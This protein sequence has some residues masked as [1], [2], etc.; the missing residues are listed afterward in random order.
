MSPSSKSHQCSRHMN[1]EKLRCSATTPFYLHP[2]SDYQKGADSLYLYK[3]CA[4]SEE[5][6]K[7]NLTPFG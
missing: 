6:D 3:I 4:N 1:A 2:Q 5:K 7:G